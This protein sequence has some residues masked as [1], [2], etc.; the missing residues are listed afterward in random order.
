MKENVLS[1]YI[2]DDLTHHDK[3]F[4]QS[5]INF[6]V[7]VGISRHDAED[8]FQGLSLNITRNPG[9]Y[10]SSKG[11]MRTY[12]FSAY[13]NLC[14]DF[15][16]YKYRRGKEKNETSL[17]ENAKEIIFDAAPDNS[18]GPL[19]SLID[20]EEQQ[21]F[22]KAFGHLKERD[23]QIVG[24]RLAGRTYEEISDEMN[25]C[26]GTVKSRLHVARGR[27]EE[28]LEMAFAME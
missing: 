11:D 28:F 20:E 22:Y 13:R 4:Y 26:I 21:K 15:L 17:G 16:R 7:S 18:L 23:R 2:V 5:C 24:L 6:A 12:L 25:I 27:L 8:V 9:R 19:D 10:E 1:R 14:T 3:S